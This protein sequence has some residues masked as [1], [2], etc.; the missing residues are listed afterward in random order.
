MSKVQKGTK[1]EK[2]VEK[3][4]NYIYSK[5]E[6]VSVK[7]NVLIDGPDGDRQIDVLITVTIEDLIFEIAVECKDYTGRLSI[8][9]IDEFVSKLE[10]IKAAKGIMISTNG[11]STGSIKKA[12]RNGIILYSLTDKFPLDDK[13]LD[14]QI[15]IE[16]VIPMETEFNISVSREA[17]L[18]MK[19]ETIIRDPI[20]I[21]GYHLYDTLKDNWKNQ[22]L[23]FKL[24]TAF[25]DINVAQ[26][27]APYKIRYYINKKNNITDEVEL[28]NLSMKLKLK[29]N[30]YTIGLNE[31][32]GLNVLENI[33]ESKFQMFIDTDTILGSLP[34]A[35][36]TSKTYV[37]NFTGVK[38]VFLIKGDFNIT[39]V[40]EF[41]SVK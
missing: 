16:E 28:L 40:G 35:K 27:K 19:G 32:I 29:I 38:A 1:F 34:N 13:E 23:N 14:I 26:I 4:I 8:G 18:T 25:Q 37:D 3:V 17:G 21:N 10:D 5:Y 7:H 15:I 24:T 33:H 39:P 2:T 31:L 6:T 20:I 22:T 41:Y 11:F 30:Y 36:P 9:K 12:K